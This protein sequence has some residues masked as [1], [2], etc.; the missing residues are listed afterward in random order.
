MR[1]YAKAAALTIGLVLLAFGGVSPTAFAP[2]YAPCEV[3]SVS[4]EGPSEAPVGDEVTLRGAAELGQYCTTPTFRWQ[5]LSAPAGTGP[6]SAT[7]EEVSYTPEVSGEYRFLLTV[8]AD[9]TVGG[10]SGSDTALHVLTVGEGG[11]RPGQVQEFALILGPGSDGQLRTFP[12][13]LTISTGAVRL[14]LTSLDQALTVVIRREGAQAGVATVLVEPGKL[15]TIEVELSQGMYNMIDQSSNTQ[16][17]Q[18]E[19]R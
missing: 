5:L 8:T 13:K 16:L 6:W 4:I 17:G 9:S 14:F 12:A 7:G 10:P 15:A 1:T 2:P 11:A 19:A 3:N 18:I